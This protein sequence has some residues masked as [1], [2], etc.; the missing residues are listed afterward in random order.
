MWHL[1]PLPSSPNTA[2][3]QC[4]QKNQLCRLSLSSQ[5]HSLY[6]CLYHY[7]ARGSSSSHTTADG[8]VLTTYAMLDSVPEITM[9]YPSLVSSL[10]LSGQPDRLALSKRH[11]RQGKMASSS[12]CSLPR[13]PTTEGIADHWHQ[14]SRGVYPLGSSVLKP[15]RP[16]RNPFVPWPCRSR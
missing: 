11:Q 6:H 9:I 4:I 10:R 5:R 8:L 2:S 1:P 15:T 3:L 12:G 16:Y 14:C 13:A 7:R